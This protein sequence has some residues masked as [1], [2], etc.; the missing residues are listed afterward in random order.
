MLLPSFTGVAIGSGVKNKVAATGRK[1]GRGATKVKEK[2]VVGYKKTK[3]AGSVA[4]GKTKGVARGVGS[5]TAKGV[6]A[7]GHGMRRTRETFMGRSDTEI[8]SDVRALLKGDSKTQKWDSQVKS[9]MVTVK[10]TNRHD[11]DVGA[12]VSDIRKIDGVRS[13]FVVAQ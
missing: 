12:V 2:T 5:T 9:G 3:G 10:T 13:I 7:V 6:R 8:Q 1:L 4:V 11:A